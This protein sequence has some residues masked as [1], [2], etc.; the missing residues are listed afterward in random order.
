VQQPTVGESVN[1]TLGNRPFIY[2]VNGIVSITRTLSK[3]RF[4]VTWISRFAKSG[5]G[6]QNSN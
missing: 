2:S 1:Q 4:D 3:G 5:M 6:Q